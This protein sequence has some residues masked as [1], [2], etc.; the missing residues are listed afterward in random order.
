MT[1]IFAI[2]PSPRSSC[3]CYVQYDAYVVFETMFELCLS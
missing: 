3:G 1:S 2:H